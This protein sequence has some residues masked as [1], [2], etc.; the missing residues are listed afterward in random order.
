MPLALSTDSSNQRVF[1]SDGPIRCA[2][3]E[4]HSILRKSPALISILSKS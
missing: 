2:I 3:D 4:V 1:F